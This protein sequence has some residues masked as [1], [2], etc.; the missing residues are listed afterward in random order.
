MAFEFFDPGVLNGGD[1][2]LIRVATFPPDPAR[3]LV[4][5]MTFASVFAAIYCAYS[6]HGVPASLAN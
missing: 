6:A 3:G 2:E 4:L 5:P 1:F